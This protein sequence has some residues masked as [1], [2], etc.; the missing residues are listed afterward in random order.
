MDELEPLYEH[1]ESDKGERLKLMDV[2]GA[3]NV[4]FPS[5]EDEDNSTEDVLV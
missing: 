2:I 1:L 5:S 4:Y 3:K